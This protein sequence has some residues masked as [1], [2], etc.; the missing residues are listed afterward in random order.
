MKNQKKL[1]DALIK[2]VK[3]EDLDER[4]EILLDLCVKHLVERYSKTQE[5][6]YSYF[7]TRRRRRSCC[8]SIGR[9]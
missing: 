4:D 8:T 7:R 3:E 9:E 5:L 2:L 6:I 1:G